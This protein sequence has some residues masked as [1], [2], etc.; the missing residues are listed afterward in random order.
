[1]G[2]L[3]PD[4]PASLTEDLT[5]LA[6]ASRVYGGQLSDAAGSPAQ[7]MDVQVQLAPGQPLAGPT[8]TDQRALVDDLRA[9][10]EARQAEVSARIAELNPAILEL[11]GALAEAQVQADQLVRARDLA[12]Q[13]FER[14]SNKVQEAGIAAQESSNLVQIA[15]P[16]SVPTLKAGPRRSLNILLGGTLGLALG[17]GLAVVIEFMRPTRQA[18]GQPAARA[19]SRA[20]NGAGAPE[21][22]PDAAELS[23]HS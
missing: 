18:P 12:E 2:R 10:L 23:K 20:D 14:L 11:Q 4:A 5:L 3:A 19:G 17:V 22:Y 15:S 9:S 7:A 16:A 1:L 6:L 21:A 8:V 13:L